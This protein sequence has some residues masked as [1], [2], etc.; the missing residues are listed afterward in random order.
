[1]TLAIIETNGIGELR[2][3]YVADPDPSRAPDPEFID[4]DDQLTAEQK[5]A[6]TIDQV[7]APTTWDDVLRW[8]AESQNLQTVQRA[9]GDTDLSAL[10]LLALSR[11][12]A[13]AGQPFTFGHAL[14]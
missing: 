6:D 7:V 11:R 1:V 2:G 12:E 10:E 14:A 3:V 4:P 13:D 8:L 9:I 5:L